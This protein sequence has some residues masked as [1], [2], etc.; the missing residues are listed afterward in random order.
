M[1]GRAKLDLPQ[2]RLIDAHETAH[3]HQICVEA[4]P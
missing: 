4:N 2:A 3:D 1:Y